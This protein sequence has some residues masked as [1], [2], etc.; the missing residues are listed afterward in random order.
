MTHFPKTSRGGGAALQN[1]GKE[2]IFLILLLFLFMI[3]FFS[4]SRANFKNQS[5]VGK[6]DFKVG[7]LNYKIESNSL[8]NNQ[9]T[10]DASESVMFDITITSLNEISS[11]YELYYNTDSDDVTV[12]YLT[13]TVDSVGGDIA[14][15]EIKTIKV[16]IMNNSS[17]S[18]TITFGVEGGY[19]A[20]DL[21]I[22]K[23]KKI[24]LIESGIPIS[25]QLFASENL[26]DNCLTYDDGVDTF[27]VGQCSKNYVWYSGK[28]WR[29]V[30]KNNE[31]G[32]VK[33]VTDN[34]MTTISF[35]KEQ[36]IYEDS[37]VDQWLTQ[38]FLPTLHDYQSYLNVNEMWDVT[39]QTS[40]TYS[41]P[42]GTSTVRRTVG[43]LNAYEF[44]ITY[45]KLHN[46]KY[47]TNSY[48][49]NKTLF[50]TLTARNDSSFLTVLTSDNGFASYGVGSQ[51]GIRPAVTLKS[52]IQLTS[53]YGD[54]SVSNPYRLVGDKS[55]IV[56]GITK[57]NTRYSGEYVKFNNELYRIVGVEDALTKITAIDNS[58]ILSNKI[59]HSTNKVNNF[60]EAT[61]KAD[62]DNY[63]QN[64]DSKIKNMIE[65]NTT[66]YLGYGDSISYSYKLC[67]CESDDINTNMI[68]CKKTSNI[69]QASIGLPRIG[70]I[71]TSQITRG[72]KSS[73]FTLSPSSTVYQS[74][75]YVLQ[76]KSDNSVSNHQPSQT[77]GVRPSMYL[78]QNVV[79]AKDN[80]GD[81]TYEHP[82][83][84]ELGT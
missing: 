26:G 61:I 68:A 79:I 23:G 2:I 64:L 77:N 7:E 52:G 69:T 40:S 76:V 28:L 35:A 6:V 25:E 80:T 29:V 70:E 38:E 12:G 34:S 36:S 1:N 75:H 56:N 71:F 63:Y 21:S 50:R 83:D 59:F 9:I 16:K 30:L 20:N 8:A 57:L 11:K 73:F 65:P 4:Y 27:L 14:K 47:S 44:Y 60:G 54:G 10:V 17:A 48:L 51:M 3:I 43:L 66:W 42:L 41:R 31:T 49:H 33:M 19:A 45:N 5:E 81:G 74:D 13:T 46:S 32:T 37:Y 82:Y 67:I 84:I 55:E 15:N 62:L 39:K 24:S 72:I 18:Q 22:S 53:E 78:K 58:S